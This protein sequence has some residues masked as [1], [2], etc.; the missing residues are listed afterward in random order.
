M[1]LTKSTYLRAHPQAVP[2]AAHGA[3]HRQPRNVGVPRGGLQQPCAGSKAR[4]RSQAAQ[5]QSA[6]RVGQGNSAQRT[7][8]A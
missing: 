2:D 8:T 3:A 5:Q 4:N 6:V 1:R 7:S